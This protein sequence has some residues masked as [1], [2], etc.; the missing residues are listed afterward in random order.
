MYKE[1][2]NTGKLIAKI[3]TREDI[4]TCAIIYHYV[5]VPFS[6]FRICNFNTYIDKY[7]NPREFRKK[8]NNNK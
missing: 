8:K 3:K 4:N 6:Q 1:H 7:L 5:T 2:A